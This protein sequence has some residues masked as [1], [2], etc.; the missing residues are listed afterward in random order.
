VT[1]IAS[2]PA[3][4]S[5]ETAINMNS[6]RWAIR[7]VIH[8]KFVPVWSSTR[9]PGHEARPFC[10]WRAEV[11]ETGLQKGL[12]QLVGVKSSQ[13]QFILGDIG[14]RGLAPPERGLVLQIKASTS[15]PRGSGLNLSLESWM[16]RPG[17]GL[18]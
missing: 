14:L 4:C 7:L 12:R 5:E 8:N 6:G 2:S 10:I 18:E 9:L 16:A 15:K 11:R 17:A 13:K 3:A 1:D